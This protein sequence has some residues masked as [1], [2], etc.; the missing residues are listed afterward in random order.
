M[1]KGASFRQNQNQSHQPESTVTKPISAWFRIN[2]A[3]SHG[4]QQSFREEEEEEDPSCPIFPR[5][6]MQTGLAQVSANQSRR[7]GLFERDAK[8]RTLDF[9]QGRANQNQ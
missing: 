4:V 1:S 6:A 5:R 7:G 2:G 8:S 9:V 3:A